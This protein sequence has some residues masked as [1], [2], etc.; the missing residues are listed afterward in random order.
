MLSSPSWPLP[1]FY[2]KLK[3]GSGFTLFQDNT[4]K[5]KQLLLSH[6]QSSISVVLVFFRVPSLKVEALEVM[7]APLITLLVWKKQLPFAMGNL[8]MIKFVNQNMYKICVDKLL[9]IM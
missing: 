3:A 9:Q 6:I 4:L 8:P 5:Y 2:E 7:P 1:L